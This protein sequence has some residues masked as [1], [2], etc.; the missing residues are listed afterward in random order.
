MTDTYGNN[1]VKSII[2]HAKFIC[3]KKQSMTKHGG[4]QL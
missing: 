1:I 2:L 4:T 3:L